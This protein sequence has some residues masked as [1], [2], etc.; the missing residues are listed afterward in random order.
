M[1]PAEKKNAKN[2]GDEAE[3]AVAEMKQEAQM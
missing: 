1:A 3:I 2:D